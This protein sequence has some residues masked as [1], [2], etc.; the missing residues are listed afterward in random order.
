MR[1]GR[2]LRQAGNDFWDASGIKVALP[3]RH[4]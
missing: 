3:M 2:S 4:K 1:I